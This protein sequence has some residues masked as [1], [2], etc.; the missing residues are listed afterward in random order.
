MI[1]RLMTGTISRIRDLLLHRRKSEQTVNYES[2]TH[3]VIY[4]IYGLFIMPK[5]DCI[6]VKQAAEGQLELAVGTPQ[7]KTK[8][9]QQKK[10]LLSLDASGKIH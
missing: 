9:R 6:E 10:S 1:Q 8:R 2:N 5:S 7:A 4:E 3:S